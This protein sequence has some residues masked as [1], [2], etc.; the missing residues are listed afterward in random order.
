MSELSAPPPIPPILAAPTPRRR[1]L[2]L[3][4]L[5][6]L[7][8]AGLVGLGCVILFVASHLLSG[9]NT[10]THGTGRVGA[11]EL[12]ETTLEDHGSDDKVAIIEIQGVITGESPGGGRASLVD[13]VR[14]QLQRI[15]D[16]DAVKAVILR[17]DSPG[18]EVLASDEIYEAL[19]K[20]QIDTEIPVVASMGSLAASGGYYVSAPCR[21]I[22]AH[23]LSLTGSIGVIFHGYNYRGLMDKVGVRP[24][25]VKS[26]KLKDMFSG[27]LRLEDE[28]PEEKTILKDL[29]AESFA[30]FKQVIREGRD[31][32]A[33][34]NQT[35][36]IT[37][38]RTLAPNW[39]E[40]ADGRILSGRQA[41]DLGLVD[42][43]GSTDAAIARAMTLADIDSANVV[44]YQSPPHF[45]DFLR[46]LGKAGV[47]RIQVD[48]GSI[49]LLTKLPQGRLYFLSPT[50]LH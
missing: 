3:G 18:G 49:N 47:N 7:G 36:P 22:V 44:T 11:S 31:W 1:G 19:R 16:D 32:A 8:L 26:G 21:W 2:G 30:R 33:K 15:E 35:N 4:S 40:F 20:F 39:E 6:I 48:L 27:E 13:D 34:A 9:G 28:L 37:G 14:D 12:V 17:V 10:H 24:E 5:V 45:S 42:E 43:L 38:G 29:V 41:L 46:F 23:P 25:V 50:H